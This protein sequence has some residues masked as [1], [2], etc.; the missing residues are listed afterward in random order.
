LGDEIETTKSTLYFVPQTKQNKELSLILASTDH[1]Y[2]TQLQRE[3]LNL[4]DVTRVTFAGEIPPSDMRKLLVNASYE[5]GDKTGDVIIGMGPRLAELCVAAYGGHFLRVKNAIAE[6]SERES[7]FEASSLLPDLDAD[8]VECLDSHMSSRPLLEAM[9]KSGFAPIETYKNAA[10]E[11]IA[12]LNIG[13]V[14]KKKSTICGLSKT[15]WV[16]TTCKYALIPSSESARLA[17]ATTLD[18]HPARGRFWRNSTIIL[19]E[20]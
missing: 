13:G 5:Q 9:A 20:S 14:V 6:L 3:G 4:Q 11:M 2:P 19:S 18:A 16:N 8:S 7:R 10:V 15:K 12:K 17:I 1:A